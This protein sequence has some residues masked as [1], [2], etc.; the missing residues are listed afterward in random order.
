MALRLGSIGPFDAGTGEW[1]TYRARVEQFWV[2]NDVEGEP[3]QV[4]TVLTLIGG[5]TYSLLAIVNLLAP[6][7]PAKQKLADIF[8]FA[9][10]DGHLASKPLV[11][12]ERNRFKTIDSEK[13]SRT[14]WLSYVVWLFTASSVPISMSTSGIDS[15]ADS[16]TLPS[17]GSFWQRLTW[18]CEK[19][20]TSHKQW[21][22]SPGCQ[23]V[24]PD[25]NSS[26]YPPTLCSNT[27]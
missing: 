8:E 11:I 18:I 14:T 6:E 13:P 7:E 26:P 24:A 9:T 1:S 17:S 25:G 3:K 20:S 2:A 10:L 27:K 21:N 4:A 5:P 15:S 19:P 12:A 16:T 22:S 23:Q